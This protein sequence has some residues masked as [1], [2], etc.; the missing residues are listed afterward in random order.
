M[1][2]EGSETRNEKATRIIKNMLRIN[3]ESSTRT[4]ISSEGYESR[5]SISSFSLSAPA[6]RTSSIGSYDANEKWIGELLPQVYINPQFSKRIFLGS[7][8][9]IDVD[10]VRAF[11]EAF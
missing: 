10:G 2:C 8:D 5:T 11:L 3:G 7:N 9:S 1:N 6:S 4:S